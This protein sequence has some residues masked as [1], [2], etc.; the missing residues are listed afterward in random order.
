[1]AVL[2]Y[3]LTHQKEYQMRHAP[4]Y[5][6]NSLKDMM[7]GLIYPAVLGTG[8]VLLVLH[9]TKEPSATAGF[10]D[11]VLYPAIAAGF[12][13]TLSFTALSE[14]AEDKAKLSYQWLP[15]IVDWFEVGLMFGCFYSLGLLDERV[16]TPRLMAVY[17]FLLADVAIIQP[18][19]R[20]VAGVNIRTF[21]KARVMVGLALVVGM[22]SSSYPPVHPWVDILI[23]AVVIVFVVFYINR[24][25]RYQMKL[26]R[27]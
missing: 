19:W 7:Y 11:P 3:A 8:L 20:L 25:V 23:A 15:F 16:T 24:D 27:P 10:L 21:F 18:I 2:L 12:F 14:T 13:Y 1:L 4:A 9:M 6:V 22:I 26:H 17:G 5:V